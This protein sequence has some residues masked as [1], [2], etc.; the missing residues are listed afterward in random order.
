MNKQSNIHERGGERVSCAFVVG[1]EASTARR[2][3]KEAIKLNIKNLIIEG[4]NLC[5]INALK[6]T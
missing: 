4:D 3:I 6:G 5:V 1:A 2:G